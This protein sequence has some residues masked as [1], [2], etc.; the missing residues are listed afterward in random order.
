M[1]HHALY[2]LTRC[3]LVAFALMTTAAVE[4]LP[5]NVAL[6]RPTGVDSQKGGGDIGDHAVDGSIT[7]ARWV[8]DGTPFPHWIEVE[9]G[10]SYQLSQLKFW[11][12]TGGSTYNKA[13]TDYQLQYWDGWNWIDLLTVSG[14]EN[15]GQADQSFAPVLSGE[16]VRLLGTAAADNYFRLYEVEIYGELHDLHTVSR[17][18]E[19]KATVDRVDQPVTVTFNRD[20][21]LAD[22]SLLRLRDPDTQQPIGS[23]TASASGPVLTI[24]PD[25]DL[26]WGTEM[27]VV[28][29]SG[30]IEAATDATLEN[31]TLVWTFQT[32][33]ETPQ[34]VSAPYDTTNPGA[35]IELVFD[36]PLSLLDPTKVS[37]FDV[38]AGIPVAGLGA[39]VTGSTL[40]LSHP[41]LTTEHV[42]RIVIHAGAFAGTSGGLANERLALG[43][44]ADAITLLDSRFDSGYDGWTVNGRWTWDPDWLYADFGHLSNGSSEV[45]RHGRSPELTLQASKTYQI[46]LYTATSSNSMMAGLAAAP[47]SL[48]MSDPAYES[49]PDW[50]EIGRW[51]YSGLRKA[52]FSPPAD[53]NY[54]VV[55]T[56]IDVGNRGHSSYFDNVL[57]NLAVPPEILVDSP[58]YDSTFP[59]GTVIDLDFDVLKFAGE[60]TSVTVYDPLDERM[61]ASF[62]GHQPEGYSI[63]WSYI[64]TPGTRDLEITAVDSTGLQTVKTHRVTLTLADGSLPPLIHWDFDKS[65]EGWEGPVERQPNSLGPGSVGL[66]T[67]SQPAWFASPKVFLFAGQTY[68]MSFDHRA[69]KSNNGYIWG[70]L[71]YPTA[72]YPE[73][74]TPLEQFLVSSTTWDS[75]SVE[76]TVPVDGGY[77]LVF[78]ETAR[79][80]NQSEM[81]FDNIRLEGIFNTAPSVT[82]TAPGPG[83]RSV[84]GGTVNLSAEAFDLDGTV[85]EV[86][87]M[88]D[89]RILFT[90]TT[91]PYSFD[92]ALPSEGDISVHAVAY[93]NNNG[94][95]ATESV[96]IR[97]EENRLDLS[98]YLGNLSDNE[99]IRQVAYQSDG[100]LVVAGILDP[101]VLTAIFPAVTPLYLNGTTPGDRGIVARLTETGDDLVSL[102]IVGEAAVD[103]SLD[104]DDNIHVAAGPDGAVKLSPA[105]DSV[106]WSHALSTKRA[107]RVDTGPNG[108]TVVIY[109]AQGNYDSKQLFGAQVA[110]L[111]ASGNEMNLLSGAGTFTTDVC[112]DEATQTVVAV[113]FKNFSTDSNP[114]DVPVMYGRDYANTLVWRAYDWG[115]NPGTAPDPAL[116]VDGGTSFENA[117]PSF[118]PLYENAPPLIDS[119]NPSPPTVADL[120]ALAD[121]ATLNRYLN[122]S[123]TGYLDAY[124]EWRGDW[125][126]WLNRPTNNMADSRGARVTIGD[127]GYLYGGFEFDGGN[128]PLRYNPFTLDETVTVV[129]GDQYNFM[130]NTSTVPKVFVGRYIPDTGEYLLGQWTTARLSNGGDNTLRLDRG[131]IH[132]DHL[133][134]VHI[135]GEASASIDRTIDHFPGGY[136]GGAYYLCLSP[137]FVTRE[138]WVRFATRGFTRGV[139]V[140]PNGR[141]AMGGST[142]NTLFLTNEWQDTLA[143]ET[144]AFLIAGELS[145]YFS[146]QVGEHPRL[147][148]GPEDIADLREKLTEE[149]FQSMYQSL[150][151]QRTIG[152]FGDWYNPNAIYDVALRAQI[153]GFLYVLTD[154]EAYAAEAR[155]LV[156]EVFTNT[157]FPW[158]DP[159]TKGLSLYWLAT[160]VALAYDWCVNSDSWDEAFTYTVSA[161]LLNAARV[162]IE[163]GGTEQNNDPGSNWQ[164]ARGSAGGLALLATDHVYG[165]ALESSAWG[166]VQR[167][168][169]EAYRGSGWLSEGTG[170][171]YFPV[172]DYIAP[173]GIAFSRQEPARD[174]RDYPS[175]RNAFW[176]AIT[177]NVPHTRP[178]GW[179]GVK[180]DWSND[181]PHIGGE[182]VYGL[183]FVF[184]P[185]D[186]AQP[187]K[188]TYDATQG[189]GSPYYAPGVHDNG[190]WDG[191]RGG[192]IWSYL[193][194]PVDTIGMDPSESFAWNALKRDV[195]GTGILTWRDQYVDGTDIVAQ[196]KPRLNVLGGNDGPDGLGFR[197]I[198][199]ESPFVVG[200]GRGGTG[201]QVSQATVFPADPDLTISTNLDTGELVGT[202]LVTPRGDGHAIARM[203]TNNAQT[204]DHKRW[205]VANFDSAAS[206]AD[207]AFLVADTTAN[208]QYWSFPT[209]FGN[210][211]NVSG[212]TFTITDESGSTLLGTVLYPSGGAVITTGTRPRGSPY[213]FQNGGFRRDSDEAT[214]PPVEENKYVQVYSSSG[215]FLIAMT[216]VGAGES[217]PAVVRNSGTVADAVVTIGSLQLTLLPDDVLYNGQPYSFPNATVT[218]DP[219]AHGSITSGDAVQVATYGGTVTEPGLSVDSGYLFN[220]WDKTYNPVLTD[221]TVTATYLAIEAVPTAPDRLEADGVSAIEIALNWRDKSIGETGF[222]IES[223]PDGSAWSPLDTVGPEVTSY[224]HSGLPPDTTVY[225]RVKATGTGGESDW[226]NTAFATTLPPNSPPVFDNTPQLQAHESI[227][228]FDTLF[229]S[230]PE[231]DTLAITAVVKPDWLQVIDFGD[232]SA[233][234][235]G[236]PDETEAGDHLITL[237]LSDGINALVETSFTINVNARP[238]VSLVSPQVNPVSL[239][240]EVGL[241]LEVSVADE[242]ADTVTWTQI[243][244][245]GSLA[246]DTP[247]G[248]S[249][250]VTAT[251]DGTYTLRATASDGTL[252]GSMDIVVEWGASAVQPTS[253][254]VVDF[255]HGD[256]VTGKFRGQDPASLDGLDWDEDGADDGLR[257]YTFREDVPLSPGSM[258]S[259]DDRNFYG[260]MA[261]RVLNG[262]IGFGDLHVANSTP[263][264]IIKVRFSANDPER[265]NLTFVWFWDKAD[266]RNGGDQATVSFG[267]GSELSI[268][269][270]FDIFPGNFR[271]LVRSGSHY[272]VSQ[273]AVGN[274]IL[275]GQLDSDEIAAELWAAYHPV[276]GTYDMDFDQSTALYTTPSSALTDI[277]GV[278]LIWDYDSFETGRRWVAFDNFR[279]T[280]MVE[281]PVNRGPL[282]DAGPGGSTEPGVGFALNA[283]VS[284]E[285]LPQVPGTVAVVWSL[286]NGPGS[287]SFSSPSATATD[288]TPDTEGSY[289]L[290]LTADDGSIKT[291]DDVAVTATTSDPF[292][293][294][295]DGYPGIP[296]DRRGPLDDWIGDGIPHVIKFAFALDPTVPH[297]QG[298]VYTSASAVDR[299]SLTMDLAAQQASVLYQVEVADSVDGPW[300]VIAEAIAGGSMSAASGVTPAP[301]IDTNGTEVTVSDIVTISGSADGKRFGRVRITYP[302]P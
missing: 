296:T 97:V 283:S 238:V 54:H 234:L 233:D 291:F 176:A 157:E 18:P 107:H 21:T 165:S 249:N 288:F 31:G 23:F 26:P 79:D 40:T 70:F 163:S 76:F 253:V 88:R 274:N 290:R 294:W 132:A 297:G 189:T 3:L 148:F 212:N 200:G 125:D 154:D 255:A 152:A 45:D 71:P 246:F 155:T 111:D 179:P 282:V 259:P 252:S 166:R 227:A 301:Q 244:G 131:D 66:E 81:Q 96:T 113:G 172:G 206:W 106:L 289:V 258:P 203:D 254:T 41:G 286:L 62:N 73:G 56:S 292:V 161:E 150:L 53:G 42:Y 83:I 229:A 103:M 221:M 228:Y 87:F 84:V 218:F 138:L 139:A 158:A 208:G 6:N 35:D 118:D 241:I 121:N 29:P 250:G 122:G 159:G 13:V 93:D 219:G 49:D 235:V 199:G 33:P 30:A 142:N 112:I 222:A 120:Q 11:T 99:S 151:F 247:A 242:T 298:E 162:I 185:D 143:S 114:V 127:D 277:T 136:G 48:D 135:V 231:N 68:R 279:A 207:A 184:A 262:N 74:E 232:G 273:T 59:E 72:A 209:Y 126:R 201:G 194:Y 82:L 20:I 14:D 124:I 51:S 224:R 61:V 89:T 37:L 239:P 226:S 64:T 141:I 171:F 43:F 215:D 191:Y 119:S 302:V 63:D 19:W 38:T 240:S 65:L 2:P 9:L 144:D 12:G 160:R 198:A 90:D 285:G 261:V 28:I 86:R 178:F 115:R 210:T 75:S 78:W 188:H 266:F 156:E 211:V 236:T 149:P 214:N 91:P 284:D 186:L 281:L 15:G 167:Y 251:M 267:T 1:K 36:R 27:E 182:G 129:G 192:T 7:G 17:S 10:N 230:D 146:F 58:A 47:F 46:N 197:I 263:H 147:F 269:D 133:G 95:A 264:D 168:L 57:V 256:L 196:F 60:I 276:A 265:E 116:Y 117:F 220:G 295:M 257:Y 16:R 248:L 108:T 187:Y 202:P 110:L 52:S 25:A 225:Y 137:D 140:S 223:S 213:G 69:L 101:E 123:G 128:T 32:V 204:A 77:H 4:A 299:L 102:A 243:D 177:T 190:L 193:Y 272:Y 205:F 275:S 260:G 100:S 153:N 8:S 216:V 173:Y 39:S 181:G 24:S 170:Y 217:H 278:G 268:P 237:A 44:Y 34:L 287:G 98:T 169:D 245:P 50:T 109:S 300:T 92:W 104:G 180:P 183:G 67:G 175:F 280:A 94:F 5:T 55:V 271:W 85:T 134:R 195:G 105:G 145:A 174:L 22:S 130:A 270:G 80:D 164:G 293:A